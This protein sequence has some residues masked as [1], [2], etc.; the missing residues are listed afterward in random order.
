MKKELLIPYSI[1]ICFFIPWSIIGLGQYE[2]RIKEL[3]IISIF[4]LL[5]TNFLKGRK[6]YIDKPGIFYFY[7]IIVCIF[8]ALINLFRLSQQNEEL[9]SELIQLQKLAEKRS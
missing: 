7:F 3:F 5:F 9:N 1:L 8:Y 4:I 2:I 6:I